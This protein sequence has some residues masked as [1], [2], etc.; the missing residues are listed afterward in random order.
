[1]HAS[2][3]ASVASR[4]GR[5]RW[6]TEYRELLWTL[7]RRDLR[8]KYKG[9]G[10]GILWSF[11]HPLV[12]MGVYTLVFSVLFR[13]VRVPNYPLFVLTGLA[14]WAFFQSAVATG[15]GSLYRNANL[16]KNVWFPR[17]V[18]PVA[19]VVS[20]M[21]SAGVMLAVIL[22]INLIVEPGAGRTV[23]LAVPMFAAFFCLT[24]GLAWI[25]STANVFFRDVEHLISVLF[26]PWFFLT[27]VL[28]DFERLPGAVEYGWVIEILRY[29]NPVAPY[30][31]GIRG[32]I[33]EG[34]V[35]NPAQLIYILLV[36]PVV[37]LVG[38][39]LFQRVEDRFAVEL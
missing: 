39:R 15:T 3:S 32:A 20:Q 8:A 24:L 2:A 30:I 26:L 4:A 11:V 5:F 14:V 21:V 31:E 16:I 28:Y 35:P 9:S 34:V 23:I 29:A 1:V 33:L 10:L 18:I 22:P 25:L 36:G 19:V 6:L 17:E 13:V 27:P 38:L 7:V 12:M 37:A